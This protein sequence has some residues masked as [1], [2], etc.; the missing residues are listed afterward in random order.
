MAYPYLF[1]PGK[2][3]KLDISNRFIMTPTQTRG[4]DA[5][6]YVTPELIAFHRARSHDG[7]GPGLVIAQQTF[8][9]PAVRLARGLA[10]WDD[11]YVEK[12]SRLAAVIREGGS[13]AVLQLG[14]SG[15]R[16]AGI[17]TAPSPVVGSWN[18][19]RPREISRE[20]MMRNLESYAEAGRRLY[21]AGFEGVSLHGGA[22]KYISQFLSPWSNRRTDEFGGSPAN[23]VRYP[24]MI[25]NAIR[26]RTRPD[27]PVIFRLF[28][29]EHTEG[30]LS[31]GEGI[32]QTALLSEGGVDA[33]LFSTGAQESLWNDCPPYCASE[34][35]GLED[36]AAVKKALPEVTV[37]ANCGIHDPNRAERMLADGQADFIGICRPL[38]A[39]PDYVDKVR[40]G[41]TE[42]IR[43]CLRCNN[44]QTWEA[45]PAL[46]GRGMCCTVNPALMVEES[47]VSR[48]APAPKRVVVVGG[49]L[50][51]M[52]AAATLAERGHQVILHEKSG[53]PGGQWLA[54]SAGDDKRPFRT[55][56]AGLVRRMNDAGVDIHLN[57]APDRD[58]I[59]S[60]KPDVVVLATGA[61]PRGLT[62][63]DILPSP[64]EN[65]IA[66]LFG[67]DVLRGA[68]VPGTK[69][70]VIGGRYIGMECAVKLAEQGHETSLVEMNEIGRGV[71]LRIRGLL[72]RRMMET[73]VR[74]F[75]SS[76][77]FRITR[78]QVE[79]AHG[80]S[81][82]P[83]DADAVILAIGT[84]PD[85][86]LQEH[87]FGVPTHV[88][89]DCLR[90]GDARD[91]VAQGTELGLRL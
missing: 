22:G 40:R 9:W 44:C 48:P 41:R 88:I 49:G 2:I 8:A 39:D 63:V 67:I 1:S 3:G 75:P 35:P 71:I 26:E 5:D 24:L 78:N 51:G 56:T 10:L 37:I 6:G 72:F 73:G 62:G 53:E 20:E 77:V 57:S 47:F 84:V 42:E 89:G 68:R 74:I 14:G 13:R 29:A 4:G 54:A 76:S 66:R 80:G 18:M 69:A 70:M 85:K 46:A 28:C 19:K 30:G 59:L 45:R 50:A 17:H 55:L 60:E 61:R 52:S 79:I 7:K 21:E 83:L 38:L 43:S 33:F 36:F 82:F 86:S 65:G 27:F 64:E 32:E 11:A 25:M 58:A 15:S 81:V 23:R 90:I 16:L 31:I 91:A 12:L 87:D 34:I